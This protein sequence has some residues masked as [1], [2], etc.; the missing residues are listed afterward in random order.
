M[1]KSAT[2]VPGWSDGA[3]RTVK[4]EGSGWSKEMLPMVEKRP[5]SYL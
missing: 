4:M 5:R 1:T 2:A 3:D